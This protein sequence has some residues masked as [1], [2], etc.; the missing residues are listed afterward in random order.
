MPDG[1]LKPVVDQ[2]SR[3]REIPLFRPNPMGSIGT[4]RRPDFLC[5]GSEK[6]GTTWLWSCMMANPATGVPAVKEMRHF[7]LLARFDMN[8]LVA[9]KALL[10]TTPGENLPPR[11]IERLS[12][13]L[14]MLYGGRTGYLNVFGALAGKVV[15]DITP[16]Y[17]AQP[18]FRIRQMKK[19]VK[20]GAKIIYM[21]RDPAQRAL[22]GGKMIAKKR[23][24]PDEYTDKIILHEASRFRQMVFSHATTHIRRF[25][26]V[27]GAENV[28]VF[29][30]D[31]IT[32]RP[33]AL[34]DEIGAF[35]GVGPFDVDANTL[36]RRV[37]KGVEFTPS[38]ATEIAMYRRLQGEYRR[39]EE[40]Y[41]DRVAT[42]RARYEDS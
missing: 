38:K 1:L 26:R 24:A 15:G 21:L 29:F 35:L 5:V 34:L 19:V 41:P 11:Q 2:L 14:R 6:A 32:T 4:P 28:G 10:N 25:Q 31:D 12:N 30:Y 17:C 33:Q 9:I 37:N 42:W 22:S 36:A 23:F 27:F 13:E 40:V 3:L 20:P 16:Q 8:H 7:N 39:L 18:V